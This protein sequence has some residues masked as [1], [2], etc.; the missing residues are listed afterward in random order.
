MIENPCKNIRVRYD[1][2]LAKSIEP[3]YKNPCKKC[4]VQACC[5]RPCRDKNI[6]ASTSYWRKVKLQRTFHSVLT[7]VIPILIVG[8]FIWGFK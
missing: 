4:I 6:Y 5:R 3:I 1:I 7:I 2:P 8:I